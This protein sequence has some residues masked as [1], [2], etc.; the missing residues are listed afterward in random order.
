MPSYYNRVIGR[1]RPG[2]IADADDINMIQTNVSD[3]LRAVINDHH[4]NDAFILGEDKNAFLLSPA[5]K[6]S[7]RYI[8]TMNLVDKDREKWLSIRR[9]GYRQK[10]KKSKTSLY[11]IIAKFRN[12][13]KKPVTVWCELRDST[14]FLLKRTSFELPANTLASEFEIVFDETFCSTAPGLSHKEIEPFDT[15]YM[16][17][18]QN[19][20][21]FDDGVD[22]TNEMNVNNFTVGASELYFVIKPLNINQYDV[23]VNGDEDEII[24]DD[25]FAVLADRDGN[26]GK[27]LEQ[28]GNDGLY[29]DETAYDLHFRDVYANSSTYL[30]EMGEAVIDGQKVKCM[31]THISIDGASEFGNV[32]TYVYMDVDGHLKAINSKAYMEDNEADLTVPLPGGML[33]IGIITTYLNDNK[34]PTINQ[35]D[36]SLHVRMRSHHERLRRLEKELSY[37]KDIA[38]PPRLKYTLTGEDIVD[39]TPEKGYNSLNIE[40]NMPDNTNGTK[41]ANEIE[42]SKFYLTTDS[43]GNFVIRTSSAE[44]ITIPVT[45]LGEKSVSVDTTDKDEKKTDEKKTDEKEKKT[46]TVVSQENI[47]TKEELKGEEAVKHITENVNMEVDGEKGIVKLKNNNNAS[48]VGM[49]DE[50]AKATTFN[51]WDDDASNRP[52]NKD[53]TPTE[54]E[55]SVTKGKNGKNDWASEFPA[56]TFYTDTDYKLD[57][58]HIPITKFKNCD[59]IKFVIWKR[60]GPNNKT[61]TVWLEKKVYTSKDF[62]LENA[63]EK[64][65]YQI[66]EDGFTIKI[67]DGLNLPKGQY[68]IVCI[69]TPKEGTGSCYV[70]TYKPDNPKDFCIRYYGAGDASHFLL[71]ERYLEIWYNSATFTGTE[72]KYSKEGHI[73]S[74][75]VTYENKEPIT[76][77]LATGNIQVP[78]K[79]EYH[80]YADTGGGWQELKLDKSTAITGG[81]ISF[82]WKLEFKGDSDTPVLSYSD[83]KKYALNFTLTRKQS[84]VGAGYSDENVCVTSKTING[85][86]IL[87]EYMGNPNLKTD[88]FSNWEFARIWATD[89]PSNK[90]I[91]DIAGSDTQAYIKNDTIVTDKYTIPSQE[92]TFDIFSLYYCDLTLDDFSKTSVDYSHYDATTE[93]DEHNL[94]LKLDY[95]YSYNDNDIALF[96]INSGVINENSNVVVKD[97]DALHFTAGGIGEENEIL[98]KIQEKGNTLDLTKYSGIKIGFNA[99]GLSG[100]SSANDTELIKGLGLY[101][102]SSYEDD[103]PTNK[104]LSLDGKEILKNTD[105]LPDLNKSKQEIINQYYGKIIQQNVVYNNVTYTLYYQYVKNSEGKYILQQLHD[106]KSYEIFELPPFVVKKDSKEDIQTQYVQVS[107]DGANNRLNNVK[108]IGLVSLRDEN[109]FEV[110]RSCTI[111]L[112]KIRAIE[113]DYYPMYNP[114][115]NEKLLPFDPTLV[116]DKN[117]YEIKMHTEGTEKVRTEKVK[118]KVKKTVTEKQPVKVPKKDKDGHD[119]T[120]DKGNVVMEDKKDEKGEIVYEEVQVER[121]VDEEVEKTVKTTTKYTEPQKVCQCK[122]YYN[123]ISKDGETLF[124]WKNDSTTTHFNHV[125]L[126]IACDSWIPKNSLRLNLCS[127]DK[128]RNVVY[129]M[130]IPTLNYIHDPVASTLNYDVIK[131]TNGNVTSTT[132][133][134]DGFVNLA[135][136]F[137]KIKDDVAIKS[138]SISATDKFKTYMQKA[139]G[140]KTVTKESVDSTTGKTTTTTE[141]TTIGDSSISL[142]IGKISLYKAR[143]IP[144]FENAIRFKFYNQSDDASEDSAKIRKV[145]VVAE[146]R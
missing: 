22:H 2:A 110:I 112:K 25:T 103:A 50:E 87:K 57:G 56:M 3:A 46:E 63:K 6:R 24:N 1:L 27:L 42:G 38:F 12:T 122:V 53:V 99:G 123:R 15:K 144:I 139:K 51:P 130:N 29:Y 60:Q 39:S 94:R 104:N 19:Q 92:S 69:H 136:V 132:A 52:K 11:S 67:E 9:Y 124:Y 146:Y 84:N 127:D 107:I 5:P 89:N 97:G 80:L 62:S 137:K 118:E 138:I 66:M 74:G 105:T 45:L 85:N 55:Y 48:G 10:I 82:R 8:D 145:G 37:T 126:Q 101:I 71:K 140:E 13:S 98:Y 135:A 115:D 131:D 143:T 141:V 109:K 108:E 142:Y 73:I 32:K 95:D 83:E 120:D 78:E 33:L 40:T 125:G 129:S 49:T 70:E 58:I 114:Q 64:D 100:D 61:N 20:E 14:D 18:P 68:V 91:V 35:D 128:G 119:V 26:Y 17:P 116:G 96:D 86:T 59:S 121:L 77:I 21:S 106:L 111:E 93:Y 36:T 65:G 47:L 28:T 72:K 43:Q 31:D 79:C 113:S 41:N 16:A 23:S 81:G 76:K 117:H 102:S 30:C 54:R 134:E 7:G 44:V 90:M 75:T 4:Q 88:K 133:K 34:A